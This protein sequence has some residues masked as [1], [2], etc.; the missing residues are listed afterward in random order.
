[1]ISFICAAML[2]LTD[3]PAGG[4]R[5]ATLTK[6]QIITGLDHRISSVSSIRFTY[7]Y[8]L[9]ATPGQ[10][11]GNLVPEGTITT[12]RVGD[13]FLVDAKFAPEAGGQFVRATDVKTSTTHDVAGGAVNINDGIDKRFYRYDTLSPLLGIPLSSEDRAWV[14]PAGDIP[15]SDIAKHKGLLPATI[16][17]PRY[18]VAS[19]QEQVDGAWCHVV[20]SSVPQT[21]WFKLWIDP[22]CDF[23]VRRR[24]VVTGY[25]SVLDR[26]TFRDWAKRGVSWFPN[27]VTEE[28]F[29]LAPNKEGGEADPISTKLFVVLDVKIGD[30]K[31]EEAEIKL[32][33]GMLVQDLTKNQIK[34][35]P[36]VPDERFLRTMKAARLEMGDLMKPVPDFDGTSR[37]NPAATVK[38]LLMLNL[39]AA[40]LFTILWVVRWRVKVRRRA[41]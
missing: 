23:A 37:R 11:L 32:L 8:K 38:I 31:P 4:P 16:V 24:E 35:M 41:S 34:M 13:R 10:S 3:V 39:G 7:S 2:A 40:L 6:D 19:V 17:D 25:G 30:V 5:A 14:A 33:P 15:P 20:K 22:L 18:V 27:L 26:A 12:V 9:V 1:M 29:A 21:I 28:K 36:G